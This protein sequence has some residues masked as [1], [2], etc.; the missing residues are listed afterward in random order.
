MRYFLVV[1]EASGDLHAS[2]LMRELLKLDAQAE[3]AFFGGDLMASVSGHLIKHYRDM[4]FMGFIAVAMNARTILANMSLCKQEIKSWK[5]DVLILVDYASFNLRIAAFVKKN[6]P[7]LSVHFYI[8]PKIWAWK[9]YRIKAFRKYIDKMYVILP[10]ETE[11]FAKHGYP[12]SYV[13]NPSVD[14]VVSFRSKPFDEAAFRSSYALDKR[15]VLAVLPGSRKGE[16]QGNLQLMLQ[17][18]ANYPQFQIVV[19]GAPG[20][21]QSFYEPFMPAGT[22]LIF[23]ETYSLL[24]IAYTAI[25]TSG[26]ATLETCLFSTPQVVCYAIRGGQ[27]ANWI[28][29]H[30]M[31]VP[32][33]SLVNLIAGHTVVPE[34]MG[35]LF[36]KVH[37]T[38]A[39]E[40]LLSE[41]PERASMLQGYAQ[42][43]EKLGLPGAA[44]RTAKLIF[45]SINEVFA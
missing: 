2:N 16:I 5:P 39:L 23:N 31:H 7:G 42:V 6:I 29:R 37:L 13:G 24:E 27:L 14:S 30:F 15:P 17:V 35:A 1:G 40:P 26:T 45:G 10:F 33:F 41:T 22:K 12:V 19:A 9:E 11:F 43:Q 21:D 34:L 25:V 28:F 44:A 38:A 20:L 8:S 18:A 3:F 36:T 32:Y 4:A